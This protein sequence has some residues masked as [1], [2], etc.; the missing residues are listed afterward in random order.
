MTEKFNI[1]SPSLPAPPR[2]D[3]FEIFNDMENQTGDAPLIP[4]T[5]HN[6]R[7]NENINNKKK[8]DDRYNAF[9]DKENRIDHDLLSFKENSKKHALPLTGIILEHFGNLTFD[10]YF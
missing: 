1:L 10:V 9:D 5:I 4:T 8:A 2:D 6:I 3:T 7:Q